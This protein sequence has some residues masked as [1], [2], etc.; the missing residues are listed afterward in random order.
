[1]NGDNVRAPRRCEA[2]G[3][4]ALVDA[5]RIGEGFVFGAVA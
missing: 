4:V 3:L 2:E 1:M 5:E